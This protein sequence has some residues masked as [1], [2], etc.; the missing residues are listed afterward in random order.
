MPDVDDVAEITIGVVEGVA[1]LL[2]TLYCKAALHAAL[3]IADFLQLILLI[4]QVHGDCDTW[5]RWWNLIVYS[6]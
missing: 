2:T 4:V 3:L 1:M 5:R 6:F